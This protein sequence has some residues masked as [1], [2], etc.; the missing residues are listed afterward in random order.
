MLAFSSA[1]SAG[2]PTASSWLQKNFLMPLNSKFQKTYTNLKTIFDKIYLLRVATKLVEK[3]KCVPVK[4]KSNS[5]LK[6]TSAIKFIGIGVKETERLRQKILIYCIF[7]CIQI[8][9]CLLPMEK[10]KSGKAITP[11]DKILGYF[12]MVMHLNFAAYLVLLYNKGS[13]LSMYLNNIIQ[14]RNN[15][16]NNVLKSCSINELLILTSTPILLFTSVTLAPVFVLIFPWTN[17]VK[18]HC[19]VT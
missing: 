2:V 11:F 3:F 5:L 7:T 10:I 18:N 19:L 12:S 6:T 13:E 8:I 4:L 15:F 9:Q 14:F 17:H 16:K 1:L